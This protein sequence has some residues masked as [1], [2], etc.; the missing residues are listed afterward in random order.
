MF[1][2]YLENFAD[3]GATFAGLAGITTAQMFLYLMA[4][5]VTLGGELNATILKIRND[6]VSAS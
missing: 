4:V 5:I 3:Y 1:A 6:K 2:M